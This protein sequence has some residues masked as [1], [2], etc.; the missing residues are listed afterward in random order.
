MYIQS[1][2]RVLLKNA[3][4]YVSNVEQGV[5]MNANVVYRVVDYEHVIV[6]FDVTIKYYG[7]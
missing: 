5:M 2:A 6:C 1:G 3:V 4:I 7:D